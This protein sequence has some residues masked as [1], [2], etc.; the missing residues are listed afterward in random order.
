MVDQLSSRMIGGDCHIYPTR[1]QREY[2]QRYSARLGAAAIWRGRGAEYGEEGTD[3]HEGWQFFHYD[4][5]ARG[6][7]SA[8]IDG[9]RTAGHVI[10]ADKEVFGSFSECP[11]LAPVYS[12]FHTPELGLHLKSSNL[13]K[14]TVCFSS[15]I[16]YSIYKHYSEFPGKMSL[17]T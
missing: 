6:G 15:R 8:E 2:L 3:D 1:R 4:T 12:L 16:V 13:G 14:W 7:L 9:E 17:W 5:T 10:N 11:F